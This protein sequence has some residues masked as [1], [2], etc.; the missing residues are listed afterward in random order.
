MGVRGCW[1]CSGVDGVT[2]PESTPYKVFLKKIGPP[3]SPLQTRP[4]AL[5][6]VTIQIT[7]SVSGHTAGHEGGEV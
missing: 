7:P 3:E 2:V 1:S 5:D 4:C 6:Q